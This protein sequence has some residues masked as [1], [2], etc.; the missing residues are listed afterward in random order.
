MVVKVL[1]CALNYVKI[2]FNKVVRYQT[3]STVLNVMAC[4]GYCS[5]VSWCIDHIS[6]FSL[7]RQMSDCVKYQRSQ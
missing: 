7:L 2:R 1:F 6:I 5:I 4:D 3:I